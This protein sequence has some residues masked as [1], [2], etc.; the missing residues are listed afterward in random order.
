MAHGSTVNEKYST[1]QQ[2]IQSSLVRSEFRYNGGK[3]FLPLQSFL[4]L[5]TRDNIKDD[6]PGASDELI[7][8][9]HEKATKTFATI[10]LTLVGHS[11]SSITS[12]MESFK[13]HGFDDSYLPIEEDL[14]QQLA[15]CPH[16]CRGHATALNVF[17][18]PQLK[19]CIGPL[20]TNQWT[21]LVP[22]FPLA[23]ELRSLHRDC[24]LPF[25]EFGGDSKEG[26]FGEVLK[27]KLRIDHQNVIPREN[28]SLDVYV[29]VK[30]F[31]TRDKISLPESEIPDPESAW[32][33]EADS[34]EEFATSNFSDTHIARGIGS[35]ST[36][37]NHY[38]IMPWAGGGT[39]REFWERTNPRPEL[40][41]PLIAEFL[42][43]YLNLAASLCALHRHRYPEEDLENRDREEGPMEIF[44]SVPQ[45]DPQ[46][47]ISISNAEEDYNN[48]NPVGSNWRHGDLKPENILRK[49]GGDALGPLM[50]GDVGLAKKHKDRTS[51]RMSTSTRLGTMSYEPPEAFDNSRAKSRAYD[52]W[53]M[54]C[55]IVETVVWLLY[56]KEGQEQFYDQPYNQEKG[57]RYY[58]V[59]ETFPERELNDSTL[60]WIDKMLANDPECNREK[61]TAIRDLL[62]LAR[63]EL[64][65]VNPPK[66]YDNPGKDERINAETFHKRLAAIIRRSEDDDA[67]LF[68]GAN[69]EGVLMPNF[70]NLSQIQEVRL[71]SLARGNGKKRL[72]FDI[73]PIGLRSS[74]THNNPT[75]YLQFH[76]PFNTEWAFV[77]DNTFAL[78]ISH[79]LGQS[80]MSPRSLTEQD[81]LCMN[82]SEFDF[83]AKDF[84]IQ[85][86]TSDLMAPTSC[87]FCELR[88]RVSR[89][90]LDTAGPDGFRFNISYAS[91]ALTI[92]NK[93][94][95]ALT[96]CG[97]EVLI[98]PVVLE[99]HSKVPEIQIGIPELPEGEPCFEICRQWL[100]DCNT[101]DSCN[102]V[103]RFNLRAKGPPTRLL[104]VG[105]EN[106]PELRLY[107]PQKEEVL[108]YIALSHPWGN[109]KLHSHFYT[110]IHNVTKHREA[111]SE[112]D[113]PRLFKDAIKLTRALHCQYL[114]IDSLC[115]IQGDGGD[116]ESEAGRMELV[117]SMAYCVIATTHATGNSDNF[118]IP[119]PKRDYVKIDKDDTKFYVCEPIDDFQKH[120]LEGHLNTRGWVLQ[121]R[122]LAR[123]TIHFTEKQMY[124][125]CGE[126]I[127]CETMTKMKN[128]QAAF[129][130]DPNFPLRAMESTKG[131]KTLFYQ[132][133]YK[134]Y[135]RL[136]FSQITDRRL[137]IAGLEQRL[138]KDFKVDGGF[139]VFQAPP[140]RAK[141]QGYFGRSLL[142]KRGEDMLTMIDYSKARPP[143]SVPSWSWMAY[144]GGIDYMEDPLLPFNEVVW[145]T[146]E[147]KSPW[148]VTHSSQSWHTGIRGQSTELRG[149][150][151][152]FS[153]TK[154]HKDIWYDRELKCCILE[155]GKSHVRCVVVGNAMKDVAGLA[156]KTSYVLLVHP[157]LDGAYERV[158]VAALKAN[159]VK[160][161]GVPIRIA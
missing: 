83:W 117:Y 116:F 105:L 90:V 25:T 133:L 42:Q 146:K 79:K 114:W 33:R 9:V 82:C 91:S 98:V 102:L 10:L 37:G 125:E 122:A 134:Q 26:T 54:G 85:D 99:L 84:I 92:N 106:A 65:V 62:N 153:C 96:I 30:M 149:T 76:L 11:K 34:M 44:F 151:R 5:F 97:T 152:S 156:I 81:S 18:D 22:Q 68:T 75:C 100:Q 39:L 129:L 49:E 60:E 138:I 6:L 64:L 2:S 8:F 93:P 67:Y 31:K 15:P 158:G 50:I 111:I 7:A 74:N 113:L 131:T 130:G 142:W 108:Q 103:D 132:L 19:A 21:F 72:K 88:H 14:I 69:R 48:V 127:R 55:I 53:S 141:D 118:L 157:K 16:D 61:P 148:N 27:A 12:V 137:G 121:E 58:I 104:Y 52:I 159:W 139:G 128:E 78:A 63:N 66:D 147:I 112:T 95:P 143:A 45:G 123:R 77:N 135:S 101:H 28:D 29:A 160:D 3:K 87:G 115:I 47:H 86:K 80:I 136:K 35:F 51:T 40:S 150:A 24:I 4:S 13:R 46:A 36:H 70:T 144:K 71:G 145:E 107:E 1:L 56:G 126:G 38:I 119:R 57:T 89:K 41:G 120:V 110:D 32:S 17:H 161:D 155:T 43:Q 124:W 154:N 140:G 59:Q 94:T 73:E 23:K 20:S 109:K